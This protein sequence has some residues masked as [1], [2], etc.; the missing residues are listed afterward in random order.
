MRGSSPEFGIATAAL[1]QTPINFGRRSTQNSTLQNSLAVKSSD[2]SWLL[3]R[4]FRFSGGVFVTRYLRMTRRLVRRSHAK[5]EVSPLL[6][7]SL[8]GLPAS[9]A[10]GV[11]GQ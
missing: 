5:A 9:Q 6:W 8:P 3:R 4:Y 11:A 10:A 7:R 1:S 2:H